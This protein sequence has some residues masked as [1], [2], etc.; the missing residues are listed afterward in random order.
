MIADAGLCLT[1]VRNVK[2]RTLERDRRNWLL[3][4][5]GFNILLS[6]ETYKWYYHLISATRAAEH[7]A[8]P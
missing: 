8:A 6:M 4:D 5:A 2:T 3:T 1:A 7:H